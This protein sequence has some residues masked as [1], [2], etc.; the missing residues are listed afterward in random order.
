MCVCTA[1]GC[2][3][4]GV[5]GSVLHDLLLWGVFSGVLCSGWGVSAHKAAMR[6]GLTTSGS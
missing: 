3:C 1:M 5:G 4:I 6:P 2:V